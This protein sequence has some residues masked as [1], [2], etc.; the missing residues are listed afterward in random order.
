MQTSGSVDQY[1]IN[2]SGNCG[3][4]AIKR[5]SAWVAVLLT[6]DNGYADAFCP[7][8]KLVGCSRTIS[9]SPT[10]KH[11]VTHFLVSGSQFADG[12]GLA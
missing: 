9:I 11:G 12:G 10:Q 7:D 6:S 8:L 4:N 1:N 2:I 3:T 5:N